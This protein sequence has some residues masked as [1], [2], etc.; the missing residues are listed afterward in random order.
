MRR[1][2]IRITIL[3]LFCLVLLIPFQL[4][5]APFYEGKTLRIVCGSL[6]GGGYD[7]MARLLARHLPKHIPGKPTVIVEN[8]PGAGSMIAAANLYNLEKPNGLVIGT[9][10]QGLPFAQLLKAKGVRF[11]LM[12]Y[13]WIGSTAR[14]ASIFT[15]RSDLPYKSVN[16]LRRV[17]EPIPLATAG[18]TTMTYQFPALLQEFAGLNFKMISYPSGTEGLLAVERKEADGTASVYS[19]LKPYINRGLIRPLIRGRISAAGIENLPIDEDLTT[20]G[21]GKTLMALRSAAGSFAW[22]YVAPPKT[23][24][25]NMTI[26]RNAFSRSIRDPAFIADADKFGM[27]TEYVT[28]EESMKILN[29]IF[30]QPEDVVHDFGRFI[31]F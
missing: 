9:F 22:P 24:L 28:A 17:K 3:I 20:D 4:A 21:R 10:N 19:S 31:K 27:T 25:A 5:A 11:D 2:K 16:D 26:L 8:V 14:E 13:E 7:R 15:V 30:S 18:P 6:P 23:S 1:I 29:F 12:K